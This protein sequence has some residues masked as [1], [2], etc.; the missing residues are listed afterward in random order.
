MEKFE[1]AKA[2]LKLKH[3]FPKEA[4][5]DND[6]NEISLPQLRCLSSVASLRRSST[7]VYRK[8]HFVFQVVFHILFCKLSSLF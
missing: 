2:S 7:V 5:K 3:L 4:R 1:K 8:L 6:F